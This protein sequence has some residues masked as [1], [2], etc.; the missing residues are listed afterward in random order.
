M[1]DTI[2]VYCF[3]RH[4]PELQLRKLEANAEQDLRRRLLL[5]RR[6]ATTATVTTTMDGGSSA[7]AQSA[8][9]LLASRIAD[10]AKNVRDELVEDGPPAYTVIRIFG[11]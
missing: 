1:P 3:V 11:P 10:S 7:K 9:R 6:R 5:F 2:Q 4:K 8:E